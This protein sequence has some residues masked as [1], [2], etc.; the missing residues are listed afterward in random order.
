MNSGV[1]YNGRYDFVPT[2]PRQYP[3]SGFT[4]TSTDGKTVVKWHDQN[5][6]Y[7]QLMELERK[8]RGGQWQKLADIEQKEQAANYSYTDE[9]APQG[10]VYRVRITD[11][12]GT[13]YYT[14]NDMTAGDAMTTDEGQTLYVGG[15][16]LVNG[17]FDL[18]AYDWTSGAG[19]ELVQPYFQVVPVGSIDGGSYLQAY[20]SSALSNAPSVKKYVALQPNTDYL[21]R[22][23]SCNGGANQ[24]LNLSASENSAGTKKVGMK[25]TTSWNMQQAV[26]NSGDNAYAL[27]ALYNL[28]A[29]AQFDKIEI[30]QLFT[31]R[32]EAVADGMEQL[33]HR[34]KA[35][36]AYNDNEGLSA[37]NSELQ[38]RLDAEH[39]RH[40]A[41]EHV[42][43]TGVAVLQR[44]ELEQLCHQ[45]V[46]IGA[47]LEVNR[48]FQT[49]DTGFVAYVGDL[50]DLA[51]LDQIDD[52]FDND[53]T[54]GR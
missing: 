18:G 51:L 41:D 29:K 32:D 30:R 25:N 9:E 13:T 2:T 35:V 46:G 48:D 33:R 4:V 22:V 54:G 47:A 12:N 19:K 14:N 40:A 8:V 10:A 5:G 28:Q 31:N 44:G 26:F 39:H 15:N 20:G 11:L 38:Q 24:Q 37:L 43:V 34:A 7:N 53:L 1:G 27:I 23:A 42:E 3:P 45:R 6:E 49:V 16:L 36:M 52:L 21:F 17:D 50:P